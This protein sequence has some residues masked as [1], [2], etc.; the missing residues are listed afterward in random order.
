[1]LRTWKWNKKAKKGSL[2]LIPWSLDIN[3]VYDVVWTK[4]KA[5]TKTSRDKM[6]RQE[7]QE[8]N[9]KR[10]KRKK[11][12][13]TQ[14]MFWIQDGFTLILLSF[15]DSSLEVIDHLFIGFWAK[16]KRTGDRQSHDFASSPSKERY[17]SF[18]AINN[19][20]VGQSS[21]ANYKTLSWWREKKKEKKREMTWNGDNK[22]TWVEKR[23]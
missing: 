13:R 23:I 7:T 12:H 17:K 3:L 21:V 19:W 10:G 18:I 20:P 1:M 6:G 16:E 14:T 5:M 4:P 22:L 11:Y 2:S 8:G 15:P 9:E